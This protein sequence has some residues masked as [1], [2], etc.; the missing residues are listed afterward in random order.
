MGDPVNQPALGD[1]LHPGSDEGHALA[2]EEQPIVAVVEG[3]KD[4]S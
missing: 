4:L 3:A 1:G 2:K